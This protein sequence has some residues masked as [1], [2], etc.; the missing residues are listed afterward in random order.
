MEKK[1]LAFVVVYLY[2]TNTSTGTNIQ[3]NEL[4]IN[5]RV[6]VDY[7]NRS[8]ASSASWSPRAAAFRYQCNA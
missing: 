3:R 4:I 2:Y 7:D 6:I 5:I 8:T 1:R